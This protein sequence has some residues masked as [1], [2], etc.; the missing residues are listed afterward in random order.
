MKAALIFAVGAC[1]LGAAICLVAAASAR[2]N[3]SLRDARTITGISVTG[4]C[5]AFAGV[6]GVVALLLTQVPQ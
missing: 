4:A 5:I 2:P 6:G 1:L 3:G